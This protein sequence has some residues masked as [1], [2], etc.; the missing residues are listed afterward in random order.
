MKPVIFTDL[1]G[2]LLS[3]VDYSF[4]KAA[5]AL[6]RIKKNG[7]PL[8][9]S[10]SKTR[11][12][13]EAVR[14]KTGNAHPFVSENGGG[15]F[16]PEGY[17]PFETGAK[18]A[19][20]Y[21]LITL[22]RPYFE[23]RAALEEIR[24]EMKAPIK[25]FGDMTER[26]IA[27]AAGL[28]TEDASLAKERDFDEP[29][30]FEGKAADEERLE[31]L[32]RERGFT[33]TSGRFHHILG[34]HDKGKALKILKGYYERLYGVV[35]TISLGD[36]K[37]DIPLLK[38]ADYPVLVRKADGSYEDTGLEGVIKADRAGPEGW[39]SAV[40]RILDELE[41]SGLMTL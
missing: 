40:N 38:E 22:G 1:D 41:R 2:T 34:S 8:V 39:N 3:S 7:V 29:F 32:I 27:L 12:E 23:V 33:A 11:K 15:I 16:M 19:G 24:S 10:S 31:R 36:G 18:T 13:I 6:D 37:N 30:I 25:G 35:V 9:F 26:E 21:L 28:T 14:L 17:F 20:G 4:E 5:P